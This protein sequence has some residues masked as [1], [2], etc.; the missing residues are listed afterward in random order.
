[1][2]EFRHSLVNDLMNRKFGTTGTADLLR[3]WPEDFPPPHR[4]TIW[5]WL[6][7]KIS[8]PVD[9]VMRLAGAIDL[10]P[11]ALFESTPDDYAGLCVR[12]MQDIGS[13]EVSPWS[14]RLEWAHD[15]I[16]PSENWPPRFVP[17]KY[18]GRSR[19]W[20]THD[21]SHKANRL[22]NVYQRIIISAKLRPHR[23][24]QV[25][26]FAFRS[27]GPIRRVWRPYGIVMREDGKL[28]LYH[29]RGICDQA[30]LP[31]SQEY[32]PVETWFGNEA[33]DFRIASLHSFDIEMLTNWDAKVPCLRFP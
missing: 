19:S 23:E 30:S 27:Y 13:N 2:I 14:Q 3:A 17:T 20:I 4:T 16:T 29:C 9:E 28:Q 1:M 15:L 25:W 11:V 24:P 21:H 5:R 12:L 7:G 22:Q 6:K 33:A 31:S 10:D 32:F 8:V 18:Y 26:H